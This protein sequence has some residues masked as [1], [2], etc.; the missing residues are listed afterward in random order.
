MYNSW[1][2]A[3]HRA[4]NRIKSKYADSFYLRPSP[5]RFPLMGSSPPATLSLEHIHPSSPPSY[6]VHELS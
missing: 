5:E 4:F 6:P 3:A 2:G 1:N